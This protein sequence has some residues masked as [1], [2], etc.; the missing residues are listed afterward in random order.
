MKTQKTKKA[1]LLNN[2]RI[3]ETIQFSKNIDE[4]IGNRRNQ[5]QEKLKE[6]VYPQLRIQPFFGKNIKKLKH[7]RPE[8][9]RYRIG[10]YRF[11]YEI[12]EK[13]KI[14]FMLSADNRR[15]AY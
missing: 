2:Y 10:D 12:S 14:I 3:F 5:I 6:Y 1:N 9:W 15:D 7:Y 13:E 11:F 4:L 8:T